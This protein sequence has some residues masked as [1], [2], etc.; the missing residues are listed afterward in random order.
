MFYFIMKELCKKDFIVKES[1][2]KIDVKLLD[3]IV[4]KNEFNLGV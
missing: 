3:N 2:N 1:F 4:N